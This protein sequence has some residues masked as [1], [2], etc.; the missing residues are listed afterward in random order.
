MNGYVS[1]RSAAARGEAIMKS[2]AR[3]Y[4]KLHELEISE[5]STVD[6]AANPHARIVFAKGHTERN[7]D[8]D[9]ITK[10][11]SGLAPIAVAKRAVAA[12]S[13][14]EIS[15][16]RFGTIQKT[17]ALSMFPDA[18]NEGMALAKFFETTVGRT[19]M[20]SRSR[21]SPQ[22]NFRLMK[23]E[24][25]GSDDERDAVIGGGDDDAGPEQ[26]KFYAELK[27]MAEQHM[28]SPECKGKSFQ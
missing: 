2:N 20:A 25:G 16:H 6:R 4:R 13:A 15:E 14:G 17:L 11:L 28:R 10:G 5:I 19:M 18:P 8:M 23:S 12:A 3:R 1:G 22:E 24:S 26:T 7:D 9:S 21:L 27:Q